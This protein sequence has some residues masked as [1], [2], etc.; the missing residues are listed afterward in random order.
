M[1]PRYL[2]DA[3]WQKYKTPVLRSMTVIG[4]MQ[5][6]KTT[7]VRY[8]AHL[9]HEYA[10][11]KG[12][13][14]TQIAYVEAPSLQV[15]KEEI[16]HILDAEKIRYMMVFV[17]DAIKSAHS[18]QHNVE[19][20]KLFSDVRHWTLPRGV[21]ITVYATQDFRLLDRLMRNALV[22]A[23]KTLP[24]EWWVSTDQNAKKQI[25]SWIGDP[26]IVDLLEAITQAIYSNDPE[27]SLAALQTA[28]AR[29]PVQRWG[30]RPIKGIQPYTPPQ[31]IWHR[32]EPI[33]DEGEN[34]GYNNIDARVLLRA[35]ERLL[36]YLHGEGYR[37]K[38]N[39]SKYLM[40]RS[41]SGKEYSLGP[42]G[43]IDEMRRIVEAVRSRAP[44][45]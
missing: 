19:E 41:P 1:F 16:P 9:L 15:A 26:D 42:L 28:V 4:Y 38:W 6:G 10:T 5:S 45:V 20:T 23:W 13:D 11:G 34:K 27:R 8:L 30:P 24:L 2:W 39:R 12:Y 33:E 37:L 14:D 17:D 32:I 40:I 44:S 3:D 21:L 35:V 36:R 43:E 22:Y 29:I 7:F 18:R 25:L 31:E